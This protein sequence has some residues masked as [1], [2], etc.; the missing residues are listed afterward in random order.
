ML[1]QME[2][3]SCLHSPLQSRRVG[4]E[5]QQQFSRELGVIKAE[6]ISRIGA[7]RIA[8]EAL[9][10]LLPSGLTSLG[11]SQLVCGVGLL[12]Q[13]GR[14]HRGC[15]PALALQQL[16][17]APGRFAILGRQ[18]QCRFSPLGRVE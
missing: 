3:F 18:Q 4:W 10:E 15:S 16:L 2:G 17:A 5:A 6:V 12:Q 11:L 9:P 7:E 8:G 14:R 13:H 1:G